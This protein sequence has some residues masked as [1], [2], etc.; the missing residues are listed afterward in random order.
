[1]HNKKEHYHVTT[2]AEIGVMLPLAKQCQRFLATTR[3]REEARKHS[4]LELLKQC[5]PANILNSDI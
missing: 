4:S 5:D 3:S 1:M 2:E